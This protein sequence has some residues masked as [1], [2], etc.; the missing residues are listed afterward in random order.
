MPELDRRHKKW[1]DPNQLLPPFSPFPL[2][3]PAPGGPP[4]RD[5]PSRKAHGRSL[6]ARVPHPASRSVRRKLRRVDEHGYSAEFSKA[7]SSAIK[8][9]ANQPKRLRISKT[10]QEIIG[11]YENACNALQKTTT[12]IFWVITRVLSLSKS[13]YAPLERKTLPER[14][15][16]TSSGLPFEGDTI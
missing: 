9:P 16:V 8:T 7:A 13:G 2:L 10:I 4:L 6:G 14:I 1:R 15:P 12:R 3:L 11:H 5:A